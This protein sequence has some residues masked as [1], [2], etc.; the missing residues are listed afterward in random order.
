MAYRARAFA[1]RLR[2]RFEIHTV[3][4]VRNK[5]LAVFRFWSSLRRVRPDVAYVFD[6]SY[7]AVFG[8]WLHRTFARNSLII[9]TGDAIYELMRSSGN[10][11]LVGLSLTRWLENFSLRTADSIVVR[12]T[13]HQQWLKQRGVSAEVIQD[14]VDT[15]RFAAQTSDGL[16]AQHG[17]NGELTIGLVGSSVWSEKLQMCYGWDLIETIR[18]LKDQPVKGI[19]IGDG[20]G[21]AHLKRRCRETGIEDKMIFLGRIPYEELARHLGMIDICLSTQTNDIVGQ[22]RTTGKLPLYLASGRYVLASDVGEAKLVLAAEMLVPYEGVT[23][24]EYPRRLKDRIEVLLDHREDLQRS[25]K[26]IEVAKERFDY[27]VLAAKMK[28][29]FEKSLAQNESNARSS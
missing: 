14:G 25:L 11:R 28:R 16:R 8:A 21:I 17:L 13:F 7:S 20:S 3:Y 22:V 15:A 1:S 18:L 2:D 10:R 26:N 9:E 12:G 27:T 5:L 6:I 24:S 19:M 29:V 23:D 4:R